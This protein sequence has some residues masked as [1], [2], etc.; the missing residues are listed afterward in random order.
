MTADT[1]R[2]RCDATASVLRTQFAVDER[3]VDVTMSL[4]VCPNRSTI[5]PLHGLCIRCV[6]L[7]FASHSA[8]GLSPFARVVVRTSTFELRRGGFF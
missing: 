7:M 3:D 4:I 8:R 1:D 6:V 2:M 5:W